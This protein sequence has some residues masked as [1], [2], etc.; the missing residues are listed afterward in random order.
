[1]IS[2]RRF[3]VLL[4]ALL[5]IAC[6]G[7]WLGNTGI[8]LALLWLAGPGWLERESEQAAERN[9]DQLRELN[10]I[11]VS[12]HRLCFRGPDGS[13]IEFFRDEASAAEWAALKRHALSSQLATGRST[14]I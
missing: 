11:W 3:W 7:Y 8:G 13:R 2:E 14:S 9:M 10:P 4:D 1:M 12:E 6:A 5:L